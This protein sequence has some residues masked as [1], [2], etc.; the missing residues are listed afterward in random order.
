[1]DKYIKIKSLFEKNADEDRAESM[2]HYMRDQFCFYGLSSPKRKTLYKDLLKE[3][4]KRRTID[5]ELLDRCYADM[6]REFQ[7]FVCDYLSA[8]KQ[9]LI[10]EDIQ[11]IKEYVKSRQWWDTID[12]FDRIIGSIGLRDHRVDDLMLEW[13]VDEDFWLRRLAIDHQLLRKEKTNT[14]LLEKILVNNLGSTEFF[15]N[16]AIGWALRDY[17]KTDPVWVMGFIDR[18]KEQMS[19]LSIKEG[20]KYLS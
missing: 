9:Y 14:A 11:H 16:K 17:S 3:E 5:W 7:Y 19:S 6:H 15:I 18:H 8:M 12:C 1:M 10:Y 2:A 13:S 4:K 20:S